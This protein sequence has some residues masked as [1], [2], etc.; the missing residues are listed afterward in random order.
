M[1]H[2]LTELRKLETFHLS[3]LEKVRAALAALRGSPG[4]PAAIATKRRRS[5]PGVRGH[6]QSLTLE[7]LGESS[8]LTANEIAARLG[9]QSSVVHHA[10][11]TLCDKKRVVRSGVGSKNNPYRWALRRGAPELKAVGE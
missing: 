7:A 10:L 9:T 6:V 1:S 5:R 4:K 3:E 11:N 2:V 8:N